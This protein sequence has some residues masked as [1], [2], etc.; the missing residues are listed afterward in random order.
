MN[1][2]MRSILIDHLQQ[3]TKPQKGLESNLEVIKYLRDLDKL[4]LRDGV[5]FRLG[6]VG[7]QQCRQLVLPSDLRD[8]VF[9]ALHDDLGHQGRDRTTSLLKQRFYWPSMDSGTR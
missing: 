7:E 2:P 5:I 1:D 8:V 9:R 6:N 3:G 4:E